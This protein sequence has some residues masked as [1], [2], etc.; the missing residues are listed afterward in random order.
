MN[1]FLT[2]AKIKEFGPRDGLQAGI[3]GHLTEAS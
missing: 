1:Y 2:A 3:C